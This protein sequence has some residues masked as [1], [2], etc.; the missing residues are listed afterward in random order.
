MSGR[1]GALLTR[2]AVGFIA[3]IVSI[4]MA[5]TI[6]AL[7]KANYTW[8]G[9]SK[10]PEGSFGVNYT[11]SGYRLAVKSNGRFATSDS[12]VRIEE[13]TESGDSYSFY[14]VYAKKIGT[15]TLYLLDT[16]NKQ[17]ASKKI[18]IYKISGKN[19][20]LQSAVNGN[21]VLDIQRKSTANSARMITYQ[22]NNGK[23]QRF[24]FEAKERDQGVIAYAIKCVH[25]GKYLDVQGASYMPSQPVIQYKYNGH[26][27]QLWLI[28]V[29][30]KNRVTFGNMNS[31]LVFDV[32]G[33]KVKNS[34]RMIQYYY[35]GGN[36]QKWVMNQK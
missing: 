8:A 15:T 17:V 21:Y 32:Q 7:A 24:R 6:S 2:V 30:E 31:E 29:D 5:P 23:N 3:L 22:R 16:N 35:N 13:T 10:M 34:S 27:N 25:S 18:T 9:A 12:Y 11:T 33:G 20:E 28:I 14:N 4:A 36:N 19:W 26:Y 1:R